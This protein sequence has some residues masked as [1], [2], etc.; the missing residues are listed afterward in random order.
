MMS[1]KHTDIVPISFIAGTG[2][3]FI[4]YLLNSA[5]CNIPV[6]IQFSKYG[7]AHDIWN[8]DIEVAATPYDCTVPIDKHISF[9]MQELENKNLIMNSLI[10][11]LYHTM[12]V[13]MSKISK[14]YYCILIKPFT[15]HT[16]LKIYIQ[17]HW[18]F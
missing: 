17:Y 13:V 4:S 2:G 14:N 16:T 15:S 18:F 10:R 6:Q 1:R 8:L 11:I 7:N 3:R 5:K 12:E 9:F